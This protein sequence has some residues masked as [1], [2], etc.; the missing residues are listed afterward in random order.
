MELCGD[1]EP[2]AG[3]RNAARLIIE[4]S[5]AEGGREGWHHGANQESVKSCLSEKKESIEK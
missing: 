1:S 3:V 4:R 5:G 2:A